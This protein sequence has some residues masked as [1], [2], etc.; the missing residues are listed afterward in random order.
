MLFNG[1]PNHDEMP[2][3]ILKLIFSQTRVSPGVKD[4]CL[5]HSDMCGHNRAWSGHATE[6]L[7]PKEITQ[8]NQGLDFRT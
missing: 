1:E 4:F 3:Q 8:W 7:I 6:L 5:F 2:M